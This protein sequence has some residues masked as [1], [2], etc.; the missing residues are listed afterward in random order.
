MGS[1]HGQCCPSAWTT[2]EMLVINLH[3]PKL[4]CWSSGN[5]L[6]HQNKS[7]I[8][9]WEQNNLA[10][11]KK[12]KDA[13]P[14]HPP[15]P[16]QTHGHNRTNDNDKTTTPP[17]PRASKQNPKTDKQKTE[18]EINKKKWPLIPFAPY[19]L[20]D[21]VC[22]LC[23]YDKYQLFNHWWRE[24]WN[25]E[26]WSQTNLKQ[27]ANGWYSAHKS[28]CKEKRKKKTKARNEATH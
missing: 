16:T 14:L 25:Q 3:D 22:F 21:P 26:S 23:E 12:L 18:E 27:Q 17:P 28:K 1:T 6:Q 19:A 4:R 5:I 24:P 13:P 8:I 20:K 10:S 2:S 9:V 15:T 7:L 11:D